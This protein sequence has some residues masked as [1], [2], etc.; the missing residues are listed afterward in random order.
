MGCWQPVPAWL[1]HALGAEGLR[2]VSPQWHCAGWRQ[3]ADPLFWADRAGMPRGPRLALG[4]RTPGP[5]PLSGPNGGVVRGDHPVAG[6]PGW[7]GHR[8]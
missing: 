2:A 3:M 4:V 6:R 7:V 5:D 1:G 8:R